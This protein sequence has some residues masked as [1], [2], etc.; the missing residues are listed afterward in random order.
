M[1]MM[2][3][4]ARPLAGERLRVGFASVYAWRPH[5]E[6]M[7]FL[8][9]LVEEAGHEAVFLACDA[10]LPTCYTRELRDV[11]PDWRECMLCRAGGVRS[12]AAQGV[13]SFGDN[14]PASDALM[15]R[16]REWAVSSASTL[17]RFESAADYRGGEFEELRGRLTPAVAHAYQSASAWIK[18]QRL[19][20]VC[21]FNGRI[22]ATRGI[23]EAARDAG[24]RV[25]SFERSWF[26]D[27]IQI[28]PEEN[29]L[30]L[31]SVHA[32]ARDWSDKPLAAAQARSAA[33]R[34]ASRITGTN[35]TEWR[36]YN[37]DAQHHA[38]PQAGGRRRIL[39]LPGSLNEIYG[40][41]HWEANWA[42]PT[43]AFDAII[44]RLALEPS[45]MV[46]RCHPNW[47]EKIGKH[48]GRRAEAYYTEWA[49]KR[50]IHVIAS[51]ERASTMSLIGECDAV[52]LASSS[53]ALEAAAM[54]KQVIA[55]AP[56]TY[57]EAGFRTNASRPELLAGLS[58]DVDMTPVQKAAAEDKL[59]RGALRFSYAM[60]NRLP[61]YV[62]HVRA[63][64]SSA[65]RYV[66]GA[67]PARLIDLIRSGR[68]QPDDG[69]AAVDT[70][71]E[72]EV[73]ERMRQGD[74]P[75]LQST[76]PGAGPTPSGRVRRRWLFQPIDF[77]REKMPIGDR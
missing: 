4:N 6:H 22:D 34:I 46:L 8:A 70:S 25:L 51:T 54:G 57:Q 10:N 36:A 71:G 5:V 50:G 18:A 56:S 58:L 33:S 7:I 62:K 3:G 76:G 64:S 60:T 43:D 55:T 72:D 30:G 9:R 66:P 26:G 77:V 37:R 44:E 69:D 38:W 21:V 23:F 24:I 63:V 27:G 49:R 68:V 74:W 59:R 73:V 61:Q 17:G 28:L 67:N 32:F 16:A 2:N 52:A 12:Y 35:L 14:P 40:V 48:D 42:E 11:R 45:D 15:S 13:T 53:A 65:Y 19:D 41:P 31:D 29:C 39:L 1:M 75:G 20:A 47:A